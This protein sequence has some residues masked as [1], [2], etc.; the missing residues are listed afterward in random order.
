MAVE[1]VGNCV[2]CQGIVPVEEAE[3][4][5]SWLQENRNAVVDFEACTHVHPAN[6][7]VL[8]ATGTKL[9]VL[10]SDQDLSM[11]ISSVFGS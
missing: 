3:G 10:P 4:L 1:Y 2:V 6:L 9:S 8:L 7:Q 5:L 11:W